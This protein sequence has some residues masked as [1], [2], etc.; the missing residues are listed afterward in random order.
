MQ[1]SWV[2]PFHLWAWIQ[3][4]SWRGHFIFQPDAQANSAG[5]CS[6]PWWVCVSGRGSWLVEGAATASALSVAG[7]Q[8]CRVDAR[9]SLN[10]SGIAIS[11]LAACKRRRSNVVTGQLLWK[12]FAIQTGI[13]PFGSH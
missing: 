11:G 9:T 12:K 6:L 10:S 13:A 4:I 5:M 8:N 1:S 7:S 3:V 2:W